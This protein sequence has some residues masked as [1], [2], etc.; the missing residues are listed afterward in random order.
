MKNAKKITS[1]LTVAAITMAMFVGCSSNKTNATSTTT[2]TTQAASNTK[3]NDSTTM[4]TIYTNVLKT[5]VTNKTITQAQSDKVL[6]VVVKDMPTGDKK[7]GDAAQTE[8]QKPSGT[9]PTDNQNSSGTAPTD[10][11]KPS[12]TP[13]AGGTD[14]KNDK[15]SALVTSKVITQAQADTINKNAQSAMNSSMGTKTN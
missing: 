4:K 5:L 11:E 8:G 1:L 9:P 10:G 13:R 2:S 3:K 15:L 6:A 7:Q 14:S 12:G